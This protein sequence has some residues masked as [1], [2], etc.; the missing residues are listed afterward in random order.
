MESEPQ[1]I[2]APSSGAVDNSKP[3]PL[4]AVVVPTYNE[5]GSL[6]ELVRRLF[7]LNIPNAKL[8]VVDDGSPDG[9][10]RIAREL[11]QDLDGRLVLIERHEKLGLGTAY[12]AGFSRALEEGAEYVLQMDADLSHAPEYVPAL[13]EMLREADVVVGSRYAPGGGSEETWGVL[14][15]L[16][17]L[18]GNFG[19]RA[20]VGLKVKDATSGF[21]GFRGSVLKSLDLSL[22]RCKGFGFQAEV[23][24]VCE[25]RG[26]RVVEY[27]IVFTSRASGQSKMSVSIA[28]EAIWHLL[29]L[30]WNR[31]L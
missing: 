14:R 17:S 6:P 16:L 21:K 18:A 25:R 27:P 1:L 9:T 26:Y 22:F 8:I 28:L 5:A 2:G 7:S 29:P 12:V 23:A 31:R 10:G 24:Y 11:S 4:V 3:L 30:R 20:I 19:I 15:R 13:L